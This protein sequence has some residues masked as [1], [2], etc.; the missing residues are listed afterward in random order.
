MND[1]GLFWIAFACYL[2]AAFVLSAAAF[3]RSSGEGLAR[4]GRAL[5]WL[6]LAA[7]TAS[8]V[9]RS[10]VIGTEP[11]HMFFPRLGAAF[12]AGP[13]WQA[14]TYVLLFVVAA[15]AVAIGVIFRKARAVWLPAAAVAV[16][17]EMILLDFL[18]FTRL[19]IE[20]VYEYLSF[21]SW[22]SAIALLTASPKL[23]LVV[24][25][26]ALAIVASMLTVFAAIQPKSIELQLVPALQSYWL[27]IH[28][29]LTSIAYAVFGV[30]F[31][32]GALL[33]VKAYDPALVPP[34]GKR[35]FLLLGT[36][37]KGVALAVTLAL[38]FGGVILPFREVAYAPHEVPG[39]AEAPPVGLIQVVRY[40]AA[41]LGVFGMLTFVLLW[42]AYPLTRKR[43]DRSG[44]GS[45]VFVISCLALFA[46]CL[47]LGGI[48]RVQE[49]AIA[50][51]REEQ[52]ELVRLGGQLGG[53]EGTALTRQ[54]FEA[55][56][57]RWRSLSHQAKGIL[58][59]ARWL[60]LSLEKQAELAGDPVFQSL[61]D[62]FRKSG[63]EWKP[64]IRYKDIKQIGREMGERAD[65][66]QKLGARLSFP[67]DYAQLERTEK[68]IQQEYHAREAN[69]LLPRKAA[70]QVAAFVGLSV[71][72]ATALGWALYFVLPKVRE[73]L[74]DVARLDRIGYGSVLI[75]YPVFTFG[76]LLAGAIWAHFAWGNWWS[77][78][79]KEVGSLVGWVLYTI[80]L[81]QRYREG[82]SPRSAALAAILGFLACTL[83][84]A[85]NSF[86]GGLHSYS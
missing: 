45:F 51:L 23:R 67:A 43:D 63:A 59:K 78:D 24:M 76:A 70:G 55:D 9:W 11:P 44:F 2:L 7:H 54:A 15:A 73:F 80:Y 85:G 33:L 53:H 40:G 64:V 28:V 26:A 86:L 13:A 1:V 48:T 83:S 31:V 22:C 50:D 21:A 20:K 30:A 18:D 35:R 75:G 6:G 72:I 17:L 12:S 29:S 52:Q 61:Q 46:A 10:F 5:V 34:G 19:P 3:R 38:V 81:H 4:F 60:P 66:T 58:G 14:A 39:A 42:I 8:I 56:I 27:F 65:N 47:A 74:P 25:D 62:L 68:A 41:L 57:E 69:A 71:A 16:V 84:L 79:P 49:Q 36:I 37:V 77:W 82:L 32:V